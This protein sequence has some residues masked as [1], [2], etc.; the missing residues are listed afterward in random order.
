[1]LKLKIVS[2][3]RL[4]KFLISQEFIR[5]RQVGSHVVLVKN[6]ITVVVPLHKGKDIGR[7]IIAAILKDADVDKDLYE[8]KV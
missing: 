2:G 8:K 7:G 5:T 3:E 1:M 4:I 6:D